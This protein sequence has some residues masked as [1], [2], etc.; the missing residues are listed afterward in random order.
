M[1][2]P[3]DSLSP[4]DFRYWDE[5]LAE[6]LSEAAF[7]RY[8]LKVEVALVK[9]LNRAGLCSLA[10]V[11]EIAAAAAKL[12]PA[13]I[14]AEEKVTRHDVRALVNCLQRE[15]SYEARP[16]VHML[17]TSYDIV[18]T[19]NAMRYRDFVTEAL[20][21]M[22]L[23]LESVLI[24]LTHR[25][26]DTLQIGRT[27]GQH[28]IPVTFGF[29]LA[30]FVSR[31]GQNILALQELADRLTGKFSGA[32]GAYNSTRLF[33][34]DPEAFEF[35][36]LN[37][38]D[39][40]P[41][42]HS[43]QINP[44]ESLIRLFGEIILTAGILANLADDLRHL[45]RTEIG[46]VGEV[47]GFSQVGS[48]TMPQKRNPISFENIKSSWK[49]V[50]PRFT[51]LLLDQISEHQR[52]LTNSASSRTYGE[53]AA[54]VYA[55]TQRMTQVLD[56]LQVDHAN[57]EKNLQ[58][59]GDLILAE[60]LYLL[61]ASL[62]HPNAHEAVRVLTLEAQERQQTLLQTLQ[63]Y[64]EL[65]AY[66]TRM[67]PQQRQIFIEPSQYVGIAGKKARRIAHRWQTR[68]NL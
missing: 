3:F 44:P 63:Q 28:A 49:I 68:L 37:E 14:Y 25:E 18:D 7:I 60:P 23:N 58:L 32:V 57:L 9:T 26:A 35:D 16:Y 10:V 50:V 41:A 61:L 39:L 48:S 38:L 6:Y 31:L 56:K 53:I 36:V 19:A 1:Y 27:H 40:E 59:Q 11:E 15:V 65:A 5:T 55:S 13:E 33:F 42:E 52:D 24:K 12:T 17:A 67:T 66:L 62:G 29:F 51:T 30:G 64:P 22:L 21:P 20:V 34:S 4:L 43:T 8:K 54:Y 47:F 45:Q 46:E 2:D